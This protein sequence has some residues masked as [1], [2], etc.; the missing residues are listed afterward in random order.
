MTSRLVAILFL[1]ELG[2]LGVNDQAN[3]VYSQAI[4][5]QMCVNS[6]RIRVANLA[7]EVILDCSFFLLSSPPLPLFFSFF[8]IHHHL[9][10]YAHLSVAKLIPSI[11]C[12]NFHPNCG[13]RKKKINTI[14]AIYFERKIVKS[15]FLFFWSIFQNDWSWSVQ[16]PNYLL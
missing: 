14:H 16:L 7:Y 8:T 2:R 4:T 12:K 10:T 5:A 1:S 11:L 13:E 3:Y 9:H 6:P 15:F